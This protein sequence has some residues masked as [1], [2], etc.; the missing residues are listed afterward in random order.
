[1]EVLCRHSDESPS[2]PSTSP[3]DRGSRPFLFQNS[4]GYLPCF[5]ETINHS[6]ALDFDQGP[7]RRYPS[8][9][10]SD[11]CRSHQ[12]PSYRIKPHRHLR[13]P[14]RKPSSAAV[15]ITKRST[16]SAVLA[17]PPSPPTPTA[18]YPRATVS[19]RSIGFSMLRRLWVA[20]PSPAPRLY[21]CVYFKAF[22]SL[23]NLANTII[24][25]FGST[26]RIC[27]FNN[28]QNKL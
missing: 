15:S 8:C 25:N 19:A 2:T 20:V 17:G 26:T 3:A 16:S 24:G 12:Y 4:L 13:L 27:L 9:P 6:L 28:G 1:M 7:H 10:T 18:P 5:T 14:S 11:Y 21:M 22:P 23:F